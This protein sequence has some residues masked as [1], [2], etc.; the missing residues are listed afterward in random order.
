MDPNNGKSSADV[1]MSIETNTGSPATRMKKGMLNGAERAKAAA[2]SGLERTASS[3]HTG[4][5]QI[6]DFGHSTAERIQATADHVRDIEFEGLLLEVRN[7]LRRYPSQL[8]LGAALL[9]FIVGRS[10]GRTRHTRH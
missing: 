2:A 10:I 7:L 6:S 3:L 1:T 8:L 5:D 4:T 9:G